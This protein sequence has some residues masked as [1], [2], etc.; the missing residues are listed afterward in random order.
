MW[1]QQNRE[2]TKFSRQKL[3]KSRGVYKINLDGENLI[4]LNSYD[5]Y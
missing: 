2:S 4:D 1:S 3:I 5:G